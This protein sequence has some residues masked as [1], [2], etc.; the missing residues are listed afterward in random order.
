M[1]PVKK[2]NPSN[3]YDFSRFTQG[4][5]FE[6]TIHKCNPF[7]TFLG[8]IKNGVSRIRKGFK[9]TFTTIP[10]TTLDFSESNNVFRCTTGTLETIFKTSFPRFVNQSTTNGRGRFNITFYPLIY[11]FL[12]YRRGTCE[13]N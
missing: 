10:L 3:P 2:C 5:A 12:I 7:I 1:S 6:H 11:L 8:A 4:V 9:A 13:K